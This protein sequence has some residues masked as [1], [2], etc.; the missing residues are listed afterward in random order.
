MTT[1]E[2]VDLQGIAQA[3]ETLLAELEG[4]ADPRARERAE[5]LVTHLMQLYGAGLE[6]I[7]EIASDERPGA[8]PVLDRLVSD[9]LVASLLVLHELHPVPLETRVQHALDTV[10]PYLGSHG[11]GVEV[12]GIEDDTVRVLMGGSCDGCPSSA[13]TLNYA[14]E[15]AILEAAPEIARVVAVEG[16]THASHESHAAPALIQL[17]PRRG[18]AP[19]NGHDHEAA[20]I[21][22]WVTLDSVPQT[23]DTV[24]VAH[25]ASTDVVICRSGGDLYAYRDP[26]PSC[27]A[28]LEAGRLD[29]RLLTCASCGHVYDIHLAGRAADG[30]DQ[31]LDPLPLL[32]EAG[33]IRIAIP[34]VHA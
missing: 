11:G 26:C 17:E 30:G 18:H 3:I 4:L 14:L 10:R 20:P 32:V 29:A 25:F 6:R 8:G 27:R 21:G 15:R 5:D 7:V 33:T 23:P 12:V 13:V 2:R 31:H 16:E 24:G 34:A 9:P 28:P 19:T 1:T 22:E